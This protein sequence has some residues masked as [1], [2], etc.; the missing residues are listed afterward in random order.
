[1]KNIV[2]IL[3]SLFACVA[4][5]SCDND[6]QKQYE[7]SNDGYLP[8]TDMAI[9][10]LGD[11]VNVS[12]ISES[13]WKIEGVKEWMSVKVNGTSNNKGS[14]GTSSLVFTINPFYADKD[15]PERKSVVTFR[16]SSTNEVIDSFTITQKPAYVDVTITNPT[17]KAILFSWHN[18]EKPENVNGFTVD[19]SVECKI[20]YTNI[21]V[22]NVDRE[23]SYFG[24]ASEANST[25]FV[26]K[27]SDYNFNIQSNECTITIEPIKRNANGVEVSLSSDIIDNLKKSISVSQDFLIFTVLE[28]SIDDMEERIDN[29]EIIEKTLDLTDFSE[30]G[31]NYLD[32]NDLDTDDAT[33][34]I[35][36]AAEDNAEYGDF[37]TD[38]RYEFHKV[39]GNV[40]KSM[41][42]RNVTLTQ[43][44]VRVL[45]P[46]ALKTQY[47]IPVELPLEG[48]DDKTETVLSFNLVQ[49]PYVFDIKRDGNDVGA[50]NGYHH[51]FDN[52]GDESVTY[53]LNTTGPWT[54]TDY[55]KE[56]LSSEEITFEDGKDSGAGVFE[57]TLTAE[58]QNL[59][60]ED[61]DASLLFTSGDFDGDLDTPHTASLNVKQAAFE[62]AINTL[63]KDGNETPNLLLTSSNTKSHTYDIK[64]S[65]PWTFEVL[66]NSE[67]WLSVETD[68]GEYEGDGNG[69]LTVQASA[70]EDDDARSVRIKLI[71][72]LHRDADY[73]E[74]E[75]SRIATITQDQL[76]C[77]LLNAEGGEAY[78]G[79][80]DIPA[81]IQGGSK[82]KFYVK[83]ST[84]W[85][86]ESYPDWMTLQSST[87]GVTISS[88]S[89]SGDGLEYAT[90]NVTISNNPDTEVRNET[91][92]IKADIDGDGNYDG[93][94]DRELPFT[95]SQDELV[96]ELVTADATT[97]YSYAPINEESAKSITV[98]ATKGLV[99]DVNN[100]DKSNNWTGWKF[101]GESHA[102]S[103]T[104]T[105]TYKL[106]P[107]HNLNINTEP[108]TAT[109]SVSNT[110]T[111]EAYT[112]NVTQEAFKFSV[113]NESLD[114]FDEVN[115]SVKRITVEECTG[116][117]Y[118]V[119]IENG[120]WMKDPAQIGSQWKFEPASDNISTTPRTADIKFVVNHPAANG[121]ELLSIPVKQNAY[122]WEVSSPTKTA[123][124]TLGDDVTISVKSSGSWNV[125]SP[126]GVT[127]SKKNGA[128]G[129]G[130][131]E[132]SVTLKFEPNYKE[133]PINNIQVKVVCNDNSD[134]QKTMTF[135]QE[136]YKFEV[137][138]G[139]SV[140]GSSGYEKNI[141]CEGETFEINV[142]CS[143]PTKW[144]V[145]YDKSATW[146]E[147]K[148]SGNNKLVVTVDPNKGSKDTDATEERRVKLKVKTTDDSKLTREINVIQEGYT[149]SAS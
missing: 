64:C 20:T 5:L 22:I 95:I 48:Y 19:S 149:P 99:L 51:T 85:K 49:K 53:T 54:L 110:F 122:V 103:K 90:I 137:K 77:E 76:S 1:M 31:Y 14:S 3:I 118:D 52:H 24:K 66:D 109:I 125:E 112:I 140:V 123:M 56:W 38:S 129:K 7:G 96:F 127:P 40:T 50:S 84:P 141:V 59:S 104:K 27:P 134:W 10:P 132:T 75:Y 71:S 35:V 55:A 80:S 88:N 15:E 86:I 61:V 26:V 29:G 16:N 43:Y 78:T 33:K 63:G 144:D 17:N 74:E 148:K 18:A 73:T 36:I 9:H 83:C 115:A 4:L 6:E 23:D 130:G 101:F 70:N 100:S 13:A 37:P 87:N 124:P 92:C 146:I 28:G 128:G 126:N 117:Y 34:T 8:I 21:E 45:K 25:P 138:D 111:S 67:N 139:N 32:A 39:P 116:N 91:I 119:K 135:T 62:F 60:F 143:D 120:N 121:I 147:A 102:D 105:V 107:E 133:S 89:I 94:K 108:R 145:E 30:L 72:T 68:S 47:E 131:V 106:D 65:G 2:K 81:Y 46:N 142:E 97:S 12:F 113:D 93:V 114:N 42:G 57:F 98:K 44:E 69:N 41:S 136:A 79:W 58:N 11:E 82:S